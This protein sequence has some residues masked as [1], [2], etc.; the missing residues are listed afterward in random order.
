MLRVVSAAQLTPSP[1]PTLD[2]SLAPERDP[3]G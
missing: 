1:Q 2:S 3:T